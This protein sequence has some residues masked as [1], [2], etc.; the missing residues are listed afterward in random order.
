MGPLGDRRRVGIHD[1]QELHLPQGTGHDRGIAE[2]LHRSAAE[3]DERADP[4]FRGRA[5]HVGEAEPLG[6]GR[7][8]DRAGPARVR[9]LVPFDRELLVDD[10]GLGARGEVK[11]RDRQ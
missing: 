1:H 8:S 3:E 7:D 2:A 5:H 9:I 11:I 4:A 6:S 10:G